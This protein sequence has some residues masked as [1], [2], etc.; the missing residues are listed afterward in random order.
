[1][2]GP[3][4]TV[5]LYGCD[6]KLLSDM[7]HVYR[8]LDEM[9]GL[10]DM[11]KISKPQVMP[12][13]GSAGT[14]DKGGISAFVIIAT[15]HISIH[16]FV[17]QKYASVDIFSCKAF[18]TERAIRYIS[19]KFKAKKIE[20]NLLSRGKEFPKEVERAKALVVRERRV[21]K[22]FKGK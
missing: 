3:H 12:Y 9:P 6:A 1:M 16:T 5:D 11:K 17:A 20:T 18:D 21:I 10:L 8:I 19:G 15:S 22:P 4:L 7:A 13:E 14:F 2:F